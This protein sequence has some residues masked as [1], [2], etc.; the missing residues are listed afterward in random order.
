MRL[1]LILS[2]LVILLVVTIAASFG[3]YQYNLRPLSSDPIDFSEFD[4]QAG[5]TAAEVADQL[6][7][8]GLIRSSTAFKIYLKLN[9][10]NQDLQAGLFRLNS[11][12]SVDQIVEHLS[13][14]I[15]EDYQPLTILP[16]KRLDQIRLSLLEVG[17]PAEEVDQALDRQTY[18]DH[19]LMVYLPTEASLEGY[20]FPE[21]FFVGR[22]TTATDIISKALD[23]FLVALTSED[24]LTA[25]QDQNLNL[26]QAV[27]L[28]SIV[29]REV[30]NPDRSKAAQVFLRRWREGAALGADA[31]FV[32]A[33]AV[34][35][36]QS[37]PSLDNPYNTRRYAGL[38]PGPISNP[39]LESLL[40]V[41]FPSPT[42]YYFFVS[43]DN[44]NNYFN[45]T[46]EGHLRD[47]ELY[48]HQLC[49]L[50]AVD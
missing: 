25:Y 26:H 20:I 16:G 41:A 34:F 10:F 48:C 15:D 18:Q 29:E 11:G 23:Q 12:W 45:E 7:L 3:W 50:P 6:E 24:L 47:A 42:N 9:N 35:G 49:Q 36:G 17:F 39:S 27:T 5:W 28:A 1:P 46:L 2:G 44:G 8:Q 37:T 30:G 21:T 19:P 43:G 33:A 4:I 32:Y 38:P 13:S 31:T 40:A 22:Q 14:A